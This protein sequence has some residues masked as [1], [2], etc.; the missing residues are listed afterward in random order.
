[1]RG[2]SITLGRQLHLLN[3]QL[4]GIQLGMQ[5]SHF[6]G[7][8][9]T[10]GGK[11]GRSS[12]LGGLQ[13]GSVVSRLG[14]QGRSS[15]ALNLRDLSGSGLLG[16]SNLGVRVGTG[17]RQL[18]RRGLT[19]LDSVGLG[20]FLAR[21][22]ILQRTPQ[23]LN[24]G[25]GHLSALRQRQFAR[26][27]L[28]QLVG[29]VVALVGQRVCLHLPGFHLAL[30]LLDL[31]AG[32]GQRLLGI[33]LGLRDLLHKHAPD[34]DVGQVGAIDLHLFN[35]FNKLGRHRLGMHALEFLQV[36]LVV[37]QALK[38]GVVVD[39][40]GVHL[41]HV[42][43]IERQRLLLHVDVVAHLVIAL[44]KLPQLVALAVVGVL[45]D[46]VGALDGAADRAAAVHDLAERRAT[47]RH[48]QTAHAVDAHKDVHVVGIVLGKALAVLDRHLDVVLDLF[49]RI[50]DLTVH[51]KSVA[52]L[53]AR[54][55]KDHVGTLV[56]KRQQALNQMVDKAVLVQV[57]GLD[58]VNVEDAR[59]VDATIVARRQEL[60]VLTQMTD[61]VGA[62]LFGK[63][64][65]HH[66]FLGGDK[67]ARIFDNGVDGVERVLDHADPLL[68]HHLDKLLA[69]LLD[70]SARGLRHLKQ[71][72][73]VAAVLLDG[74]HLLG[75]AGIEVLNGLGHGLLHRLDRLVRGVATSR[76]ANAT[77]CLVPRPALTALVEVLDPLQIHD[78]IG[79][80]A[81][82]KGLLD[83]LD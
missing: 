23:L 83:V 21:L 5:R 72:A 17:L 51:L 45:H 1:M 16:G 78:G 56:H 82:A 79:Q 55:P 7:R 22:D 6:L 80:A 73:E 3:A 2:A 30:Q 18:C 19:R 40:V 12:V 59:G 75:E 37:G 61:A 46:E 50:V 32:L 24:I 65:R 43:V 26:L 57:V 74:L 15:V 8:G 49:V 34:L 33:E 77:D 53:V 69:L 54:R 29:Q 28:V 81:L 58:G 60:R 48:D 71:I 41:H 47:Q 11:L 76:R 68:V 13:L 31:F 36:A 62:N 10:H 9:L 66:L 4:G 20:S 67:A 25:L 64:E 39:E 38:D 14:G 42:L 44:H 70:R 27:C 52:D 35:L 63:R